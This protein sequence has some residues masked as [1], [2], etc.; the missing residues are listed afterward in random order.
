MRGRRRPSGATESKIYLAYALLGKRYRFP[1]PAGGR[2][3]DCIGYIIGRETIPEVGR[4]AAA[5]TGCR[6][7]IRYLVN[8]GVFV[9]YLQSRHPPILHVGMIAVSNMNALPAAQ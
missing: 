7:E 5:L 4:K 3:Q 9:A 2:F 1:F 6:K 8:E